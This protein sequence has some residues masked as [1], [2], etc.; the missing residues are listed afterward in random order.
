MV[1]IA[2]QMALM[3]TNVLFLFSVE[4]LRLIILPASLSYS[5]TA[6]PDQHVG[7]TSFLSWLS[8][9]GEKTSMERLQGN[10]ERLRKKGNCV[11]AD[12]KHLLAVT[13]GVL[14]SEKWPF[15]N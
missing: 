6:S 7:N 14:V 10:R 3:I 5:L 12:R 1:E 8:Y 11:F 9:F 13:K 15:L 4:H 2:M